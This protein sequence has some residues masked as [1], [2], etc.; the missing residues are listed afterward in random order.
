MGMVWKDQDR[1]EDY[2]IFMTNLVG[3]AIPEAKTIFKI[4]RVSSNPNNHIIS[5]AN[6]EFDF[7]YGDKS[8]VIEYQGIPVN[9][10][11]FLEMCLLSC[12][13]GADVAG[14]GMMQ[15]NSELSRLCGSRAN[16][17]NSET[18]TGLSIVMAVQISSVD[19]G[20]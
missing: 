3:N 8:A 14:V 18:F 1:Q 11:D 10:G 5:T 4:Y 6:Y 20:C 2:N 7:L 12:L 13:N 15:Y 16:Y 19:N 17:G 9:R